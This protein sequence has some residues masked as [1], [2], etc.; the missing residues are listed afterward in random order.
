MM[1]EPQAATQATA[2][3]E[4]V[5]NSAHAMT[6]TFAGPPRAAPAMAEARSKKAAPAP[7]FSKNAA[8]MTNI[9]TKVAA[10]SSAVPKMPS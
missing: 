5:P 10:V 6:A 4:I 9:T 7:V 2:L 1:I 3:P 8:K